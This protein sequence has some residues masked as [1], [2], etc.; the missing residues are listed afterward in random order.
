MPLIS[1]IVPVYKVEKYLNRCVNSLLNQ[2][3][4]DIEVVLVN[5]GSP[6]SCP[7][8]CDDFSRIDNRVKVVHKTNQGLGYARNSGLDIATGEFVAFCDSDDY[9]KLDAYKTLYEVAKRSNADVVYGSFYKETAPGV[10]KEE[11][12]E[13]NECVFENQEVKDY[14]LDMIACAPFVPIER[15]HDMS[16]CMSIYKKSIIDKFNIRF[17]SEREN[18]SED[19][20]F[21][22]DFLLNASK[23]VV[24]PYSFYYYCLNDTSLT[25]TFLPEKLDKFAVLRNQ[26]IKRLKDLDPLHQR[27]NRFYIGY[28]R[29][30][31]I[32]LFKDG[33]GNYKQLINRMVKNKV[34][35]EIASEYKPSYLPLG[36]RI[37][38]WLTV[39]KLTN[40]LV[41]LGYL[42]TQL[43]ILRKR[44]R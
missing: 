44:I 33:K 12:K 43:W 10:W 6:D 19:T 35:D 2:T 40:T 13:E 23:I 16:S 37:I 8:I 4:L 17:L 38:Y 30:Y 32:C 3:L 26:L 15:K 7:C 34:W 36:S 21:N 1:V 29:S 31:V 20:V 39:Q 22:V 18:A 28:A 24:V 5:D 9:V 42:M 27:V 11:R 25:Q 14:L 41:L